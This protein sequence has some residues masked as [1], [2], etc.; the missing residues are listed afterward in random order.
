MPKAAKITSGP[1]P[2]SQHPAGTPRP[3]KPSD[4]DLQY[5]P[6]PIPPQNTLKFNS[7]GDWNPDFLDDPNIQA[8]RFGYHF[9]VR[10]YV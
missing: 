10:E 7:T 9:D 5:T 4:V 1:R 2:R 6:P 3:N 8:I